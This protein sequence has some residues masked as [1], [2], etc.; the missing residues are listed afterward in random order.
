MFALYPVLPWCFLMGGVVGLVW[1]LA[2]R[3]GPA[4]HAWARRRTASEGRF[5]AY[6]RYL[7]KPVSYLWYFDPAVALKGALNWT[8]GNNLSY[9][10]NA[11][12]ISFFMMVSR[13]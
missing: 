13:P 10:T 9:A 2:R 1:G 8:G 3:Y 12:Y 6:E 4:L 7:F 11:M 5:A